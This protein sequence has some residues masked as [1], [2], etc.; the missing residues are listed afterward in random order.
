MGKEFPSRLDAS[1]HLGSDPFDVDLFE[2]QA[3]REPFVA[4]RLGADVSILSREPDDLLRLARRLCED[5]ELV[6]LALDDTADVVGGVR[7]ELGP[8]E[9]QLSGQAVLW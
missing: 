2:R 4:V 1:L 7:V 3:G 8:T 6:Q 9:Q 5:A